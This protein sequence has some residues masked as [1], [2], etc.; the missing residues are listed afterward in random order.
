MHSGAL[1]DGIGKGLVGGAVG[2][3]AMTVVQAIEMKVTGRE[4]SS[5]PADAVSK[6]FDLEPRDEEAKQ[7]LTQAAHWAYGTQWGAARGLLA[8]LGLPPAAAT[9]AHFALVWGAALAMLPALGLA[10]PPA[11]WGVKALVK[12]AGMHLVYAVAAGLAY[13]YLDRHER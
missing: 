9:A 6:V 12:D 1:A 13:E 4:P 5:A 8:E 11:K 7:R 3:A 2:T 10:E